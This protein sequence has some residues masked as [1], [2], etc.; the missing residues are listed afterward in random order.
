M[1][2]K[3]GF[4]T[5]KVLVGFQNVENSSV[6]GAWSLDQGFQT[7]DSGEESPGGQRAG[8]SS[9]SGAQHAPETGNKK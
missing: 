4:S 3:T 7:K 2:Q 5:K 9:A 8:K 1:C 6:G